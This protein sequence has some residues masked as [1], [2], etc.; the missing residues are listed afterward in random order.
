[1]TQDIRAC[2]RIAHNGCTALPCLSKY[3]KLLQIIN[4]PANISKF[5]TSGFQE[6]SR[7]CS[8]LTIHEIL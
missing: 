1:M 7:S 5:Y 4:N 3:E 6:V 8:V 2:A